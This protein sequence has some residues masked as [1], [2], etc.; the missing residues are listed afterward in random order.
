VLRVRGRLLT[1]TYTDHV[2]TA[3]QQSPRVDSEHEGWAVGW[4]TIGLVLGGLGAFIGTYLVLRSSRWSP[5]W[6]VAVLALPLALVVWA[7][8]FPVDVP[9][10]VSITALVVT[11]ALVFRAAGVLRRAAL[12]GS[13]QRRMSPVGALLVAAVAV[14]LASDLTRHVHSIGSYDY[15]DDVVAA[16]H[17]AE[18][19]GEPYGVITES[20]DGEEQPLAAKVERLAGPGNARFVAIFEELEAKAAKEGGPETPDLSPKELGTCYVFPVVSSRREGI[21][22]ATGLSRH[23]T[24]PSEASSS[25]RL[26]NR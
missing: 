7:R 4:M 8:A 2:S 19:A 16:A 15:H 3:A 17:D 26:S 11:I 13:G 12:R 1:R 14:M 25:L 20:L 5:G 22:S 24:G 9:S 21:E 18:A 10:W 6:K 23:C